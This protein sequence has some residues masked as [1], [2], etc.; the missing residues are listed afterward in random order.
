MYRGPFIS[1]LSFFAVTVKWTGFCGLLLVYL[2]LIAISTYAISWMMFVASICSL[3]IGAF[4]AM[5]V[6]KTSGNIRLFIA[7][8]SI[9]QM[10]FVTMGLTTTDVRGFV[11]SIVY[12]V[13]YL[14]ASALFIGI[15]SRL[16]VLK[17]QRGGLLKEEPLENLRD[18]H[19]LY[20]NGDHQFSRRADLFMLAYA[21]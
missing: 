20:N 3:F 19:L 2:N 4:G 6:M 13:T 14:F 9:N 17:P 7:Y 12:M 16:R 18:F 21:V 10:G 8:T 15:I 11:S 5:N 1:V